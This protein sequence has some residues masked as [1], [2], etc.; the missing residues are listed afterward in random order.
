[1]LRHILDAILGKTVP[2]NQPEP[3]SELPASKVIERIRAHAQSCVLVRHVDTCQISKLGGLPSVPDYFEWPVWNGAPLQFLCQLDLGGLQRVARF[4]WLP[5]AGLLSFFYDPEQSTWGFDPNDCGSWRVFYFPTET[6]LF[7]LG[8]PNPT[9]LPEVFL[10]FEAGDSLPDPER[11]GLSRNQIS[12]EAWKF[13]DSNRIGDTSHHQFGGW[14]SAIQNDGMELECQLASN[15]VY[16]G[17][18]EGYHSVEAKHLAEQ[19]HEWRLLFQLDS[20]EDAGMQWGD[21]GRL[22]FWVREADAKNGDFSGVWMV[23][24]CY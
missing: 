24:Q 6:E 11:T 9:A 12:D 20:D 22:Y 19:S 14:P 8:K 16:V 23:L 7:P 17:S 5:E 1:M 15:G 18:P 13:L 2:S 21:V 10:G 4:E 3:D